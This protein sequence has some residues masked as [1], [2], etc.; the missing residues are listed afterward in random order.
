MALAGQ[1]ISFVL[2]S[3]SAA[4]RPE[5]PGDKGRCLMLPKLVDKNCQDTKYL[6][7]IPNH[8]CFELAGD[9]RISLKAR[10]IT[11]LV[12]EGSLGGTVGPLPA[13]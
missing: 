9:S 7:S 5:G 12:K 3:E 11:A 10:G 1:L 2:V 8:S 6:W 13:H 4:I